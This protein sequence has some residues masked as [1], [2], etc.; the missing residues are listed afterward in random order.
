[1]Q[2]ATFDLMSYGWQTGSPPVLQGQ[3]FKIDDRLRVEYCLMGEL[4][5]WQL[6][7]PSY[8]PERRWHLW[9][10][11]C[12]ELFWR[13]QGQTH[14]WEFNVS[15]A[16]HWNV[17][18]FSDYRQDMMEDPRLDSI[19]FQARHA[20]SAFDLVCELPLNSLAISGLA[21]F[22][23]AAILLDAEGRRTYWAMHHEAQG[24]DFHRPSHLG[25]SLHL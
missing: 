16:G 17:F 3:I 8:H 4:S 12:F 14:Y 25:L 6:P 1:M 13:P 2:R 21:R 10:H 24:P 15:P 23:P 18:A 7:R 5:N 22:G 11:T 20:R 9:Q 19:T